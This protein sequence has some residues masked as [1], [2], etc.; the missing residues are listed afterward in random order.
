[1]PAKKFLIINPFGIGDVLF[2]TPVIRNIKESIP[3][4]FIGYWCNERVAAVLRMNPDINKIFA[5]NRGDIK[6]ISRGSWFKE[7]G[8][9]LGLLNE[10][11]KEKFE[12]A[13]DFSL[14]HRSGLLSKLAGIRQ[15]IGYN[16]K[17]RGKFLTDRINISGY[18]LKHI[19][20]YYIDLLKFAGITPRVR[21]MSLPLDENLR[22]RAQDILRQCGIDTNLKMIGIAPGGGASWGKDAGFKRWPAANFAWFINKLNEGFKVNIVLLGDQQDKSI[23]DRIEGAVK[24]KIIN[25]AGKTNLEELSAFISNLDVL[26][27]NDGG[28][29]HMAVA[30]GVRTVSIFGPVDDLVYGPYPKSDRH[31]AIR[32][33]FSCQPCYINFRFKGCSHNLKCL[34]DISVDEVIDSVKKLLKD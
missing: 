5:L 2:T 1:M 25:L 23:A 34:E 24:Q 19:I 14:D 20:E 31:I 4:S 29:L 9:W 27:A 21:E 7:P 8:L 17:N 3:D 28:P 18:G 11:K 13:F 33:H 6:R 30:L 32:R 15:R 22:K 16:Y 10:I 12:V 26:V